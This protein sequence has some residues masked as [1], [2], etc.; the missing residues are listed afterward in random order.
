ML[1]KS[2]NDID[3]LKTDLDAFV[4]EN[5]ELL[6][7]VELLKGENN[8]LQLDIAGYENQISELETD[9]EKAKKRKET[10]VERVK[11]VEVTNDTIRD[12]MLL[13]RQND[14]IIGKLES[15]NFLKD[16]IISKQN[17]V[18]SND[19]EII[20]RF[21]EDLKEKNRTIQ[22]YNKELI[23]EK[24]KKI[25][26]QCTTVGAGLWIIVSLI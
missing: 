10:I 18:I 4:R 24:R 19:E 9:L 8:N 23:R 1:Y 6:M 26:W 15:L 2:C 12:L 7:Q 14:T 11:Y 20:R 5:S 17:L 3:N 13:N 16:S 21:E 22:A 25:L